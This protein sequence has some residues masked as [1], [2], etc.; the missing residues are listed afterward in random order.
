[1]AKPI[2]GGCRER[3]AR[4]A[5]LARRV[6]D[7]EARLG[8]NSS[9]SS[10]PSSANPL[11]APKPGAKA[12]TARKP[13]A[14]PGH[15]PSRRSRLPAERVHTVVRHV[16]LTCR[17][18]DADLPVE[19]GAGD[20]EPT[21]HQVFEMPRFTAHVTEP[22]GH[23]RTCPR[24]GT[25]TRQAIPAAIRAHVLGPRLT[26]ALAYVNGSSRFQVRLAAHSVNVALVPLVPRR[27]T[28]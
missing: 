17:G 28:R 15:A 3:D 19:R 25:G 18:C 23:A 20:P 2:Y 9:N 26:A 11:A 4:I 21:W 6:A 27:S 22:Q 10:L 12:P 8:Q 5:A 24:C 13:G 7:R 16:A 14:Q 1:M